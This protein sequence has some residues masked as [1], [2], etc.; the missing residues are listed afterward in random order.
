MKLSLLTAALGCALALGGCFATS[1]APQT[2]A[3][4][5]QATRV[6]AAYPVEKMAGR[7]GVASYRE[8][9]DRARTEAMARSHCRNPYVIEAGPRGGVMMH[10]A[11]DPKLYE[12]TFKGSTTGKT[13]LGFDAPPGHD[14]DREILSFSD[15]LVVMRFV[16]PAVN[17]RY[18]TYVY[19]RCP[20]RA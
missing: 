14:Q 6:A 9:K 5:V 16:D 2:R 13:Y 20:Q 4:P 8:E 18:G 3:E 1:R 17:N 15:N 10:V 11:D 19:V 7:W 12:L